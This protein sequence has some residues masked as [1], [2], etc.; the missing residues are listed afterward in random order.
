M[1]ATWGRFGPGRVHTYTRTRRG[2]LMELKPPARCSFVP[3]A[4]GT[5]ATVWRC[6][7]HGCNVLA[8]HGETLAPCQVAWLKAWREYRK[9]KDEGDP[10]AL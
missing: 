7:I 6:T 1:A 4:S 9:Y 5:A 10:D 8:D 3:M 2:I